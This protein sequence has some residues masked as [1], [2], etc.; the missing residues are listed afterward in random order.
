M[1][2]VNLSLG[3]TL[4]CKTIKS[5]TISGYLKV[6]ADKVQMARQHALIGT[7]A[8]AVAWTDPRINLSTGK[9]APP[10][11]TIIKELKQWEMM[12]AR[13]EAITV[14]MI[15]WSALQCYSSMPCS[16]NN[17]M[18]DWFVSGIYLGP[19]LTKRAQANTGITITKAGKPKAFTIDDVKFFGNN[20]F[21]MSHQDALTKPQ[22]V[23][24]AD[25]RFWEQKNG[26]NGEK[27]RVTLCH[28]HVATHHPALVSPSSR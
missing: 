22:L 9:T 6:A 28:F 3:H 24:M 27:Q 12:P 16:I 5:A 19:H 10:I 8:E 17:I 15:K 1:Y 20:K 18:Y 13:H 7:C 21:C 2:A 4:L 23:H 11:S 26:N 14:N 25:I